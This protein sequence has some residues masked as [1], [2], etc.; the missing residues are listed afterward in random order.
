[1]VY[2][3]KN[4]I[5]TLKLKLFCEHQKENHLI[6]NSFLKH[7]I[8]PLGRFTNFLRFLLSKRDLI[9]PFVFK[10]PLHSIDNPIRG[11]IIKW[12]C[13]KE[14]K[15]QLILKLSSGKLLISCF[16]RNK[17]HCVQLNTNSSVLLLL[18]LPIK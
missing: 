3:Q 11:G 4:K 14:R 13:Y 15:F 12:C 7:R 8:S 2:G 16:N 5:K 18:T 6:I 17:N 9:L 10:E 1:M